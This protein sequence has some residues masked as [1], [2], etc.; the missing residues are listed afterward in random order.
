M[1]RPPRY[2][3]GVI[4][5]TG[6]HTVHFFFETLGYVVAVAVYIVLRRRRGDSVPDETRA[7]VFAK[8]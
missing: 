1:D 3:A 5:W 4:R 7:A 8:H 6:N 2:P